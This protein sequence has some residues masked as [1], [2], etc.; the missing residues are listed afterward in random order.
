M[1]WT[2]EEATARSNR[3]PELMRGDV[4]LSAAKP[5]TRSQGRIRG[6]APKEQRTY[7][8]VVYHSKAEATYAGMLDLL[9][10]VGSVS[11]WRRQVRFPI[12]VNGVTVCD[13]VVDFQVVYPDGKT[14]LVEVKGHETEVYILKAKLFSAA[15]P[16][17]KLVVIPAGDVR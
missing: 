8:G 15:Y 5:A 9:V 7:N 14:A 4:I 13:I 11:S 12:V 10:K 6:V 17:L 2:P 3:L 1:N 16:A